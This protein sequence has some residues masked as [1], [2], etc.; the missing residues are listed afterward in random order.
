MIQP[1]DIAAVG[2]AI[3]QLVK[4][5]QA[6]QD[7]EAGVDLAEA[8]NEDPGKCPLVQIYPLR[9]P[10]P[11]RSIGIGAGYRGQNAEFVILCQEKHPT[12]GEACLIALGELV[13]GVTG[14]LLS[15][16]T[17]GGTVQMLGDFEVEFLGTL[18][19]NDSVMQTASIR[20]VGLTTVSGG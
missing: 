2:L 11:S 3:K 16:P 17:L 15:D 7:T 18:N 12:D 13:Q 6:V 5:S 4:D 9:M 8:V 14:A 20:L 10:F 19:V 1:V